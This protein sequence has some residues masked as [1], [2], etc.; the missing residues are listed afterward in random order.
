MPWRYTVFQMKRDLP[1][2]KHN[3]QPVIDSNRGDSSKLQDQLFEQISNF[4]DS[5]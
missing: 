4:I 3:L 1:Y 2:P 5:P